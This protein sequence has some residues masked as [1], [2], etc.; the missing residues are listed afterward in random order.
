M[1]LSLLHAYW[2]CASDAI[3]VGIAALAGRLHPTA[4]QFAESQ[5]HVQGLQ[6]QSQSCLYPDVTQRVAWPCWRV[7]KQHDWT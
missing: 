2:L 1:D 5:P 7:A 6:T 4:L 3:I